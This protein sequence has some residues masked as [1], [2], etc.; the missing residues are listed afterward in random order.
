MNVILDNH[1]H[2]EPGV[3]KRGADKQNGHRG[4]PWRRDPVPGRSVVGAGQ[5]G[6]CPDQP[7]RKRYQQ[8]CAEALGPPVVDTAAGRAVIDGSFKRI[9]ERFHNRPPQTMAVSANAR[10]TTSQPLARAGL[11]SSMVPVSQ[12]RWRMPLSRW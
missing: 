5:H 6:Q 8:D 1:L 2:A 7:E 4:I 12:S 10:T 9:A 3:I 11:S